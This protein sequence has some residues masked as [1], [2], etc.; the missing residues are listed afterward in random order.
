[1]SN[2]N[3]LKEIINIKDVI[4]N[5]IQVI[6]KGHNSV[7]VCPF[8]ADKNPSMQI[9]EEKGLF[10]CFGCGAS[11]DAF[12]FVQKYKNVDFLEALKEIAAMYNFNLDMNKNTPRIQN[13]ALVVLNEYYV[14]ELNVRTQMLNYLTSRKIN[15]DLRV[16]FC[17][18]YAPSTKDTKRILQKANISEEQAFKQGVL[19]KSEHGYFASFIERITF[20]IYDANGVL[21]AFGA[22]TLNADNPAKYVNSPA[23]KLFNKKEIFYAYHLAKSSINKEKKIIICEGYMDVISLHAAGF[24]YAVAVLGTAL[25]AYHLRLI[26][27]DCFVQLCFD[28]DNAGQNA[29]FKSALLFTQNNYNG[30]VIT[31]K[32]FKDPA[33]FVEND[34]ILSLHKEFKTGQNLISFCIE[35]IFKNSLK[36]ASMQDFALMKFE[37]F[38]IKEAYA[39]VLDYTKKL[40]PYLASEHLSMFCKKYNLNYELLNNIK[41][42]KVLAKANTKLSSVEACVLYFLAISKTDLNELIIKDNFTQ[43]NL[44][45]KIC[46]LEFSDPILLDFV[47]NAHY[48]WKINDMCAFLCNLAVLYKNNSDLVKQILFKEFINALN[49]NTSIIYSKEKLFTAY[50]IFLD[51]LH[52]S[53]SYEDEKNIIRMQIKKLGEDK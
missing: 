3:K 8:H 28:K 17:L 16:K 25:T 29:A 51:I 6:S 7:C 9:S 43:K 41:I 35:Y 24:T 30:E 37:P 13:E 45:E 22:R 27:K 20:P 52:F 31:L 34:K 39:L 12:S 23:S 36:L 40:E 53:N 21:I 10:H 42:P 5:Y 14:N 11:G 46:N 48:S 49:I 32:E 44:I 38:A 18:G 2:I 26:K 19:K 15:R 50:K 1:M 47:N 33:E 4:S